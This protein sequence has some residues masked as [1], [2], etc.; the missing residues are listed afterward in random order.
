MAGVTDLSDPFIRVVA[1]PL[2]EQM[3]R[4]LDPRCR[5]VQFNRALSDTDYEVLADW[6]ADYRR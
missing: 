4:P 6:L 5:W 2:T 1:S 3:L